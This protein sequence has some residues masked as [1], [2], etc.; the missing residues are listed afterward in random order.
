MSIFSPACFSCVYFSNLPYRKNRSL[1]Y[2]C[3]AYPGGIPD[4]IFGTPYLEHDKVRN[5]QQGEFVYKHQKGQ[6]DAPEPSP[7]KK[8]IRPWLSTRKKRAFWLARMSE[9]V[10][11]DPM[12]LT[13]SYNQR[14]NP[15]KRRIYAYYWDRAYNALLKGEV[16]FVSFVYASPVNGYQFE[17]LSLPDFLL[18]EESIKAKKAKN[19]SPSPIEPDK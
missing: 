14:R 8:L 3:K 12:R 16:F 17:T 5:G 4:E 7:Y 6:G 18:L 2:Q 10:D 11:G 1:P 13:V 19:A 15:H 9:V